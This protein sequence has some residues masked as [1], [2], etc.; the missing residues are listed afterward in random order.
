MS[1]YIVDQQY[2]KYTFED[3]AVWRYI[4]RQLKFFLKD[5]AHPSYVKGLEKTGITINEIPRISEMDQKMRSIGWGA[6]SVNGF[7]PPVPF[8]EFQAK[9]YL[10]IASD[11]RTIEHI[12][13]T[14]APD[15]VHEAAGHAPLLVEEEFTRYLRE[16]ASIASKAIIN[17]ED[18]DLYLAIRKLSDIKENPD[19]PPEEIKKAEQHFFDVKNNMGSPSEAS[20]LTR[21]TWWTSEYGLIGDMK[22]PKIYGAGLLS[23]IGEA[24]ECLKPHVKKIFLTV[25]CVNYGYDITEPQPQLFVTPNFSHLLDVLYEF[26]DQMAFVVGGIEGL[27]KAQKA[28]TI[29]TVELDSGLQ[30]SGRLVRFDEFRDQVAFIKFQSGCQ[31]SYGNQ[32]LQGH[33]NDYHKEGYSTP[34]GRLEGSHKPLYKMTSDERQRLGLRINQEVSLK[35]QSGFLLKGTLKDIL[36]VDEKPVVLTFNPCLVKRGDELIYDPSWGPFDLGLGEKV[37]S[38]FGGPADR[39]AYKE[40]NEFKPVLAP[41][42]ELT[43]EKKKDDAFYKKVRQLR[44]EKKKSHWS[45]LTEEYF[46]DFSHLWLPGLE[47]VELAYELDIEESQRQAFEKKLK[48]LPFSKESKK[49]LEDGLLIANQKL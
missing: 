39:E 30:I 44:S 23:S 12:A 13:Y 17:K 19:T 28:Q 24:R 49:Y 18:V 16:Y 42:K 4:M 2:E 33:G 41:I 15:I 36:F 38:V 9:G 46:Q 43:A 31:L 10:P 1:K 32:Q 29:T 20:Q 40:E 3:Q 7:I 14:P 34:L 35:F 11:L 8:M 48:T 6:V 22:N 21:M 47:L 27:K 26:R 5:H 45:S 25:D 37:V